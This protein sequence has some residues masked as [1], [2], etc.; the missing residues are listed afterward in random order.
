MGSAESMPRG[1]EGKCLLLTPIEEL[2]LQHM[3]RNLSLEG[4]N[5]FH[6]IEMNHRGATI[7]AQ[8]HLKL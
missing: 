7:V 2:W 6:L 4:R 5:M 8:G 3:G 1:Q